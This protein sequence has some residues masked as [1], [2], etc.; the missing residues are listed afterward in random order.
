MK[1]RSARTALLSLAIATAH[2]AVAAPYQSADP[3][4][5]GPQA[6][7]GQQGASGQS[8]AGPQGGA[9]PQQGNGSQQ[10][11]KEQLGPVAESIRPY[12]SA[13]RDPFR[14]TIVK[15]AGKVKPPKA[16]G[17]PSLEARRALFQQ[18]VAETRRKDEP[19]PSP[20][21]QYLVTEL[22]VI[23][24]FKDDKGPGAFVRARPTGTTF[25]VRRGSRCYNGEVL[26]IEGESAD[27]TGSRVVF[28]EE[29]HTDVDGKTTTQDH[30][31]A[32]SAAAAARS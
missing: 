29:V 32:K 12:R 8:A 21:M 20:L 16:V 17:F 23:G 31:V 25:F 2:S 1:L 11:G 18:K 24:I 14:K 3:R 5:S 13:G 9:Q 22:D 15:P 28:R 4:S 7:A 10:R 30:V 19:E 26:K 6:G 27:L